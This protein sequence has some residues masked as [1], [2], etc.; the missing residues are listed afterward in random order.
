MRGTTETAKPPLARRM[1]ASEGA[2]GSTPP[3]GGPL[4]RDLIGR[5]IGVDA[6]TAELR[7]RIAAAA[8][9]PLIGS[10]LLLRR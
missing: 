4:G 7:G 2:H 8:R 3:P 5:P 1:F 9:T 10:L 6:R